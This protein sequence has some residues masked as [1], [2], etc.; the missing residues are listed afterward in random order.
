M[1]FHIKKDKLEEIRIL[2]GYLFKHRGFM[3]IRGNKAGGFDFTIKRKQSIRY[4]L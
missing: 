4:V 2:Y 1:D 3:I